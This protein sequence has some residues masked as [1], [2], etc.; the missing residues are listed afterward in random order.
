MD[1]DLPPSDLI[2]FVMVDRFA[3]GDP[4]NDDEIDPSDPHAFHGGDLAGVI[5]H[6]D[7]FASLGVGTLWLSPIAKSRTEPFGKWGAFHGYWARMRF[8][9]DNI[10][11]WKSYIRNF[12]RIY[13]SSNLQ[14]P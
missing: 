3:N 1:M 8:I 10:H 6:I 2:Y 12:R 14:I 9:G 5:K 7:H 4:Q 13:I 11:L